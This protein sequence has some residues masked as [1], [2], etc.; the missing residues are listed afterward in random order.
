MCDIMEYLNFVQVK[1]FFINLYSY[2]LYVHILVLGNCIN[3]FLIS[4][5]LSIF[6]ICINYFHNHYFTAGEFVKKKLEK[7]VNTKN[8]SFALFGSPTYIIL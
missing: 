4:S 1:F 6:E 7:S 5:L 8:F 3:L 2:I